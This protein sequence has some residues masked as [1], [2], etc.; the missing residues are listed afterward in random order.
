MEPRDDPRPA[1]RFHAVKP[2]HVKIVT[3]RHRRLSGVTWDIVASLRYITHHDGRLGRWAT[4]DAATLGTELIIDAGEQR[5]SLEPNQVLR[6]AV[7]Q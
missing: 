5:I 6:L 2:R 4:A 3:N 7:L 1:S